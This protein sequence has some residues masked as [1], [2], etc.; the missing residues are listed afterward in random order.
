MIGEGI[1]GVALFLY[2]LKRR[3]LSGLNVGDDY[4][5]FD[6]IWAKQPEVPRGLEE[7]RVVIQDI[8][9]KWAVGY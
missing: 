5:I 8:K 3:Y 1:K 9:L 7:D 2:T 4:N 6:E